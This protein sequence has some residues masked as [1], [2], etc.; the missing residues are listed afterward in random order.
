MQTRDINLY[1]SFNLPLVHG[2]LAPPTSD[3]HRA[4]RRV[5]EYH[6]DIQLL[7]FRK[8]ELEDK[9]SRGATLGPNDLQLLQDIECIQHFFNV[10][11][12][13][14]LSRFGL[15]HLT[16][17]LKPGS[18]SILFRNDHFSTLFKHPVSHQ[19]F[20]LVTDM[21]FA[22]HAEIVWESLVDVNGSESELYSGDFRPVSHGPSSSFSSQ[23]QTRNLH[24][25][26]AGRGTTY[27]SSMLPH[28]ESDKAYTEQTDADYAYALALQFQDEEEQRARREQ[29]R[30][31]TETRQSAP[32]APPVRPG[33][34]PGR[35]G[36]LSQTLL[37]GRGSTSR[38]TGRRSIGQSQPPQPQTVRS[39]I[40]HSGPTAGDDPNAPPPTYEQAA[41]APAYVPPAGHPQYPGP[42]T[43][44]TAINNNNSNNHLSH[45]S[46]GMGM[47]MGVAGPRSSS[48]GFSPG[49][50][51]A[52]RRGEG[53]MDI[54]RNHQSIS[55]TSLPERPQREKKDCIVM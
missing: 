40:P 27:G 1:S 48:Y 23:P 50:S 18:V 20:T 35:P 42:A 34:A 41:K 17:C 3:A 31:R 5:G 9:A 13:T 37:E 39:L 16:R 30:A 24:D 49:Q 4:L 6:E 11:N 32:A 25:N 12:A 15:D 46:S 47:G 43:T 14:Q 28:D 8:E 54:R 7:G 36:R 22:G 53:S 2:W 26:A 19:L 52:G 55:S 44:T 29:T 10:Q 21:G 45:S 33:I 38:N 51:R